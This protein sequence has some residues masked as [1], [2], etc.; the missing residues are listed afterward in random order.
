MCR[1]GGEGAAGVFVS[2]CGCRV[3]VYTRGKAFV[4]GSVCVYG[5]LGELLSLA[6]T[7]E[8][9]HVYVLLCGL[10][11]VCVRVAVCAHSGDRFIRELIYTIVNYFGSTA[12]SLSLFILLMRTI[13]G[14]NPSV[15]FCIQNVY[16]RIA[17][18]RNVHLK[19]TVD[20]I[21]K[22]FSYD[23]HLKFTQK[24]RIKLHH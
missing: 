18:F 8:C 7:D 5:W 3:G 21:S 10:V 20:Y 11:C 17:P 22:Y 24:N 4:G 1:V 12:L 6:C 2:V 23:S 16:L 15:V 13:L 14:D 9:M 19:P